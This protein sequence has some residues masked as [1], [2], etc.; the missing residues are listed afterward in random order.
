MSFWE[1]IHVAFGAIAATLW[2]VA[3]LALPLGF[4]FDKSLDDR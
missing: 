1:W 3:V 4:F 2:L